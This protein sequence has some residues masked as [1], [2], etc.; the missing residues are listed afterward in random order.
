MV[1]VNKFFLRG[2]DLV[3][4]SESWSNMKLIRG[5]CKETNISDI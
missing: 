5:N 2:G 3:Y 1:H 4:P